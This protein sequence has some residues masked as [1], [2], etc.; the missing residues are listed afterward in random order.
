MSVD[1]QICPFCGESIKAGAIKC[2]FCREHLPTEPP[3]G[4]PQDPSLSAA[5]ESST[6]P[7]LSTGFD[8]PGGVPH[9][10]ASDSRRRAIWTGAIAAMII[11]LGSVV[12][13]AWIATDSNT[14]R[15]KELAR[16]AE[17]NPAIAGTAPAPVAAAPET[18]PLTQPPPRFTTVDCA[19][20]LSVVNA[21]SLDDRLALQNLY[22][23]YVGPAPESGGTGLRL[24]GLSKDS[25]SGD[26][27]ELA[28]TP[29]SGLSAVGGF[30]D[31]DALKDPAVFPVIVQLGPDGNFQCEPNTPKCP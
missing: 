21:F 16:T 13:G 7:V 6:V 24:V 22:Q 9:S 4:P 31:F 10:D 28:W 3:T 11:I 20:A 2:R 5:E 30:F 25:A 29:E 23:A 19:G 15:S 1:E 8:V 26:P 17:T 27:Y 12:V 14:P 18:S